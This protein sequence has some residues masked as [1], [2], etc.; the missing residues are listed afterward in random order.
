M[1]AR[2]QVTPIDSRALPQHEINK[3]EGDSRSIASLAPARITPES[4]KACVLTGLYRLKIKIAE[5]IA[6]AEAELRWRPDSLVLEKLLDDLLKLDEKATQQIR[7]SE[8]T[9]RRRILA[10]RAIAT[11]SRLQVLLETQFDRR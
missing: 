8:Q 10:Q 7:E 3:L 9:M 6:T 2:S 4:T 11:V 1:S 5:E